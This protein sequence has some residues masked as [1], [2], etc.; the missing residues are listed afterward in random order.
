MVPFA[1]SPTDCSHSSAIDEDTVA[2]EQVSVSST[3]FLGEAVEEFLYFFQDPSGGSSASPPI[4]KYDV[5]CS[6][7]ADHLLNSESVLH[8]RR[9]P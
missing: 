8:A 9:K 1:S 2:R 4:R 7:A 5:I 3:F 6:G